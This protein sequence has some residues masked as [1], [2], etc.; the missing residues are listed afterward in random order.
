MLPDLLRSGLSVVFCGTA[1]ATASAERGHYYSGRGNRFWQLLHEAGFTPIRLAPEEDASLPSYGIGITDL[2][3]GIAQSH[4]RGLDFGGANEV[5]AHLIAAAPQWVA[6]NG[7]NAGRAA[8]RQLGASR[9][10]DVV[11][12][13]Q[14]WDIGPSRVFVVPNS[15]SAHA[16]MTYVDK[17]RWWTLLRQAVR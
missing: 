16:T 2:V 5:A 1:V 3:K 13:E 17:L 4:D 7:L 11:L 9:P 10:K 15:S 8:A 14:P 12:G 6:F